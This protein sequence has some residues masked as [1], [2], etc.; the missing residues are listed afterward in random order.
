[1]TSPQSRIQLLHVAVG[2]LIAGGGPLL[3]EHA[4]G[5]SSIA[6]MVTCVV[7]GAVAAIVPGMHFRHRVQ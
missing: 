2:L 7:F 5:T 4:G 3:V 6:V 1:M